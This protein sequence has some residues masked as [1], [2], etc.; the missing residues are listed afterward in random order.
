MQPHPGIRIDRIPASGGVEGLL[1][2]AATWLVFLAV[3]EV[4]DFLLIALAGGIPTAALL[5]Y[6]RHQTRW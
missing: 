2:S 3:P 5:Y 1:F 4:R 6:W